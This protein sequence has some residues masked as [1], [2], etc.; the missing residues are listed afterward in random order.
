MASPQRKLVV[1]E[2]KTIPYH[3]ETVF[4]HPVLF[5]GFESPTHNKTGSGSVV[6]WA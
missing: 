2:S 3:R 1:V 6:A 4:G 5:D